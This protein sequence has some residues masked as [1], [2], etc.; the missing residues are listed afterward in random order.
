MDLEAG[1]RSC[2]TPSQVLRRSNSS[3][4]AKENSNTQ[5]RSSK[6]TQYQLKQ[7]I[8]K[9]SYG[10]VY[11]AENR[12]TSQIVAIKEINYDNDEELNEIMIE[13]NLLK[14]LDHVNIVKYHGFIQKMSNLYIILEYASK[15]SLKSLMATRRDK[16]LSESETKLYIRQTLDGLV[17][18]HAQGVI[19]RDIKAANLLLD[20]NDVVK[21]ADFGVSTKVNNSAMTLAGSLNWMAPEIIINKGASTLSDIW[22]LGATV[23]ELLTGKPPFHNLLDI[24]IYYAMD[25][26]KEQY[27]PPAS[28]SN[29]TKD[30]LNLCLQKNMFERSNAKELLNHPWVRTPQSNG[31]RLSKYKENS[32]SDTS[33]WDADFKEHEI[34]SLFNPALYSPK[35]ASLNPSPIKST[36]LKKVQGYDPSYGIENKY[37]SPLKNRGKSFVDLN[38]K[39]RSVY[40]FQQQDDNDFDDYSADIDDSLLYDGYYYLNLLEEDNIKVNIKE[41]SDKRIESIFADCDAD[42][43]NYVISEVLQRD[44]IPLDTI[45]TIS[46]IFLMDEKINDSKLMNLFSK[47]GGLPFLI[48]NHHFVSQWY[49]HT[50]NSERFFKLVIRNGIMN[51]HKID[52]YKSDANLYFDLIYKYLEYTSMKFWYKWCCKNVDMEMLVKNLHEHNS[53]KIQ[54]IT[55]K[56]A[57]VDNNTKKGGDGQLLRELLPLIVEQKPSTDS[58][59]TYIIFKTITY[60]LQ[61]PTTPLLS[62]LSKQTNITRKSSISSVSGTVTMSPMLGSPTKP[63]RILSNQYFKT[64]NPNTDNKN[65]GINLEGSESTS[66]LPQKFSAWLFEYMNSNKNFMIKDN[67]VHVWKYFIKVCY[68]A[69]KIDKGILYQIA[70]SK[71]FVQLANCILDRYEETLK[72]NANETTTNIDQPKQNQRNLRSTIQTLMLLIVDTSRLTNYNE[73]NYSQTTDLNKIIFTVSKRYTEFLPLFVE[74]CLNIITNDKLDENI[75]TSSAYTKLLAS[76]FY[77]FEADDANFNS[78]IN[79]FIKL[80]SANDNNTRKKITQDLSERIITDPQ[81]IKRIKLFFKLYENSLLIQIELLKLIKLLFTQGNY[82]HSIIGQVSAFLKTNWKQGEDGP[83]SGRQVGRDSILIAQLCNDIAT[84]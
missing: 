63:Q 16:C 11:K 47:Y 78:V 70:N 81:F 27:Y 59:I 4:K 24:N 33:N 69:S 22:S 35:N 83:P 66:K 14:N 84:M 79:K 82:D 17:Y 67:N 23:V 68:I 62:D 76:A 73:I 29:S 71:T 2:V 25:N 34:N 53:K 36:P 5:K 55:L 20:A 48:N 80:C 7:V 31:D 41:I 64:V 32:W 57:S 52:Q 60:L 54:S 40:S 8:G 28:L 58:Q 42:D 65:N 1:N 21:L 10:I 61:L 3:N 15:G 49:T 56:L 19:H 6:S 45:H 50:A 18:L 44:H 38:D 43:I 75:E 37:Y 39:K 9:G 46:R 26:E 72:L 12:N 51:N 74:Y 77:R 30:F 13:I